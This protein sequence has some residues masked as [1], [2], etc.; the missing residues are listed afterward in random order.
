MDLDMKA[1]LLMG[2]DISVCG[3]T[4]KNHTIGKIF[5]DIGLTKYLQLSSIATRDVK[6]YISREY[7]DQFK[8][9]SVFDIFCMTQEMNDT[10]IE[11]LNLFTEYEWKF[12]HN[13]LFTEFYAKNENGKS[14]HISKENIQEI[15]ETIKMMYC[16]DS[17]K[18]E[19]EREDIDDRM[20][21]ILAELEEE[22]SKVNESK[23]T[24]V[25]ILSI[26]LG[27]ASKHNSINLLNMWDYT[28]YQIIKTYHYV[29]KI[30]NED[31]VVQGIYAGTI[32]GKKID[33]EKLHWAT[34]Q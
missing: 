10:F 28:I 31:R 3:I 29:E 9:I 26:M 32:D 1:K 5:K 12:V 2:L 11:F 6:D 21:E 19:S 24:K 14:V 16:L 4:I 22:E 25:T 27:L 33:L 13:N 18:K 17:S 23:G 15:F 7:L 30:D 34:E 20:K 8:D